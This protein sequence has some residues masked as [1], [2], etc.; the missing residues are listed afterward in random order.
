MAVRD[1]D[2]NWVRIEDPKTTAAL[3]RVLARNRNSPR[4]AFSSA[5]LLPRSRPGS[6]A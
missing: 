5:Y 1:I 3:K 6:P 4:S 2:E